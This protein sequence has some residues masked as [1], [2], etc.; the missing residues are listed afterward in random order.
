[1]DWLGL[2]C[3]SECMTAALAEPYENDGLTEYQVQMRTRLVNAV[4]QAYYAELPDDVIREA[5]EEGVELAR[6]N[7]M[8]QRRFAAADRQLP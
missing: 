4:H 1:L 5:V 2:T 7:P 6:N 8:I 3:D